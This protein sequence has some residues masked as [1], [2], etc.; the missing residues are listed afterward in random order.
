MVLFKSPHPHIDSKPD[1]LVHTKVEQL[2]SSSTLS[3]FSGIYRA[4]AV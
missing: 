2:S 4:D 3:L 1:C